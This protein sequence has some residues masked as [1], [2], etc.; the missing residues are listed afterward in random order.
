MPPKRS[1]RL[2]NKMNRSADTV[3][4]EQSEVEESPKKVAKTNKSQPVD[5]PKKSQPA[6]KLKKPQPESQVPQPTEESQA[7]QA[8][9][10]SSEPPKTQAVQVQEVQVQ[11][12]SSEPP[13]VQ[14]PQVQEAP[15]EPP[16]AQVQEAP[17]EAQVQEA[18][19]EAQVQEA[20]SEVQVQEAPSEAQV[21]E[22]PSE[23]QVQEAQLEP[24]VV[25]VHEAPLEPLEV[26]VQA[27]LSEPPVQ[28][29][30][31]EV[32][33]EP[34][35]Q[36]APAQE[37]PLEP[38]QVQ[39]VQ[40]QIVQEAPPGQHQVPIQQET[41]NV[42]EVTT[43]E[44]T[45]QIIVLSMEV[46]EPATSQAAS[47]LEAQQAAAIL[48]ETAQKEMTSA[49]QIIEHNAQSQEQPMEVDPSA[50]PIPV[51]VSEVAAV[52][53][54]PTSATSPIPNQGPSP[55]ML[56]STPL[57]PGTS[58][59]T[60][61]SAQTS[62]LIQAFDS[63]VTP[64]SL[65]QSSPQQ[66]EGQQI[67][68]VS[69]DQ[70]SLMSSTIGSPGVRKCG[71]C[72][73]VYR[74]RN[75]LYKHRLAK[76]P[77][78]VNANKPIH[79]QNPGCGFDCHRLEVLR[80]HITEAHKIPMTMMTATFS[81]MAEFILW[82]EKIE[83]EN[84]A[85][86][87]KTR[88]ASVN[89]QGPNNKHR[90]Y[91][92]RSGFHNS[93][94]TGKRRK[95][96]TKMGAY[97]TAGINVLEHK[98]TGEIQAEACITHHGHPIQ[99]EYLK[100]PA[101][102]KREIASK[103]VKG[104]KWDHILQEYHESGLKQGTRSSILTKKDLMNIQR[105]VKKHLPPSEQGDGVS[106]D[107]QQIEI[108]SAEFD[109]IPP[110][111]ATESET[112]IAV[113]SLQRLGEVV[114]TNVAT[115]RDTLLG[116][117]DQVARSC[118]DCQD[119]DSLLTA[120]SHVKA[121]LNVFK[122]MPN[123]A[124]VNGEGSSRT[125]PVREQVLKIADG[126]GGGDGKVVTMQTGAQGEQVAT[127]EI[128]A[129]SAM[130]ILESMENNTN[131][132]VRVPAPA[133]AAEGEDDMPVITYRLVP[134]AAENATCPLDSLATT[135]QYRTLGIRL[136]KEMLY[137]LSLICEKHQ[138]DRLLSG[139][140]LINREEVEIICS[141]L[142]D[143]V[144][145]ADMTSIRVLLERDAWYLLESAVE[146]KRNDWKCGLC[147]KVTGKLHMIRCCS[148]NNW[149]HWVC[150]E[151]EEQPTEEWFCPGCILRKRMQAIQTRQSTKQIAAHQQVGNE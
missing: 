132:D 41:H 103:I 2:S 142:P 139:G 92:S 37:A 135:S 141:K 148:C 16:E 35:A 86:F 143:E 73:K 101:K 81:N 5:K 38:P 128:A 26:Q 91:C 93:K 83:K 151:I 56:S 12:A 53:S 63:A 127:I 20:P 9:E 50:Q 66:G 7:P 120:G 34:P 69:F 72:G 147:D 31:Q 118:K 122:E 133:E 71:I 126:A 11:E 150:V 19:S 75:G 13:K 22:A 138:M 108:D 47:S 48:V 33:S 8:A 3:G 95:V 107:D 42:Q 24:P 64:V 40:I 60:P 77:Q 97:C 21:Q 67:Q 54:A 76:H 99:L 44:G 94:S 111:S 4:E 18:P 112:E 90:Y 28:V 125:R 43:E 80:E 87:V 145:D 36:A 23:A 55:P 65:I 140:N 25:Q 1:A 115:L 32:P 78:L 58:P 45:E 6:D 61:T 124:G 110:P 88:G 123:V 14:E 129:E 74:N 131:S 79:C 134:A 104:K 114:T 59:E 27:A 146:L 46:E 98:K 29:Q 109:W 100:I 149:F 62:I 82:K 113:E 17:S 96:T 68:Y 137:T 89:T 30:V 117:L 51:S 85:N 57:P 130:N 119:R 49:L 52:T 84:C 102:D 144:I 15:S 116:D 10:E 105:I 39:D 70:E 106:I 121:A 136:T